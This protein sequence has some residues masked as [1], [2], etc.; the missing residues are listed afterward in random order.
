MD[1]IVLEKHHLKSYIKTLRQLVQVDNGV[2][3]VSKI[4]FQL[5]QMDS[6]DFGV[7]V[8]QMHNKDK[9]TTLKGSVIKDYL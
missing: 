9:F 8:N 5:N 4:D 1:R 6:G 2:D 3:L 7:S